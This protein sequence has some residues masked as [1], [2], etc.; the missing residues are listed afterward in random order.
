FKIE[1]KNTC[2]IGVKVEI[3]RNFPTQYWKIQKSGDFGEFEKID[4]DTV[5]FTQSLEPRSAKKFEYVLTTYHGVRQEDL[6][7]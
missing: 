6:T 2:D 4:L 3:Q 1:V 5:K 7:R